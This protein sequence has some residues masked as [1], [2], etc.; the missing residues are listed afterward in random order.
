MLRRDNL[1]PYITHYCW[2]AISFYG[3]NATM[4]KT[5]DDSSKEKWEL[6]Q[7]VGVGVG[8]KEDERK[9]KKQREWE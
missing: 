8:D 4:N 2:S 5:I 1:V 3:S 7:G 6:V 9:R